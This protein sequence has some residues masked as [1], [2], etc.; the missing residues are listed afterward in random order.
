MTGACCLRQKSPEGRDQAKRSNQLD[1]Q[2]RRWDKEY[3]KVIKILLL[4]ECFITKITHPYVSLILLAGVQSDADCLIV[5]NRCWRIREDDD[6]ETNQDSAH[7]RL[8]KRVS[9]VH[10]FSSTSQI[11]HQI[12]KTYVFLTERSCLISASS[13][14][15]QLRHCRRCLPTWRI[16]N[17]P[18]GGC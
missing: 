3:R 13:E 17:Q 11:I 10:S 4:G 14:K 15:T 16:N 18:L 2:L 5:T 12:N 1:K 8:L 9:P 6:T 7:S